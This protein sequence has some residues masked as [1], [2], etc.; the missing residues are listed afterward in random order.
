MNLYLLSQIKDS[1][2]Q[3]NLINT[4]LAQALFCLI[5]YP[6]KRPKNIVDHRS[7]R[8]NLVWDDVGL[9]LESLLPTELPQVLNLFKMRNNIFTERNP[10]ML[11]IKLKI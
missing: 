4:E 1:Q 3:L 6:T 2:S 9:I 5:H 10:C 11:K 8:V 7:P